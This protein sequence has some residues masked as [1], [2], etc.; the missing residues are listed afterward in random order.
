MALERGIIDCNW[1]VLES[2]SL[3]GNS[4]ALDDDKER[5]DYLEYYLTKNTPH[6]D[7]L[8]KVAKYYESN[9]GKWPESTNYSGAVA[10]CSTYLMTL[11]T[12]LD[13]SV[14]LGIAYPQVPMALTT[15]YYLTYPNKNEM[16]IFGDGHRE[17]HPAYEEFE[18]AYY[19]G[20]LEKSDKLTKEFGALINSSIN[21]KAY[22]RSIYR[23]D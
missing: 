19:L 12:K 6:Q 16:A 9:S 8:L 18:M 2:S 21:N 14:H 23:T 1:P 13:P 15:P 5:K 4:L 10:S 3:V 17:Y 7:A 20:T 11:L 22:K